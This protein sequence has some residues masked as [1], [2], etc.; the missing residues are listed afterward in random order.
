MDLALEGTEGI[1][2]AVLNP[3]MAN[4]EISPG[5]HTGAKALAFICGVCG[6]TEVVP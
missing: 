3:K 6:T 1:E 4:G 5:K 2:V